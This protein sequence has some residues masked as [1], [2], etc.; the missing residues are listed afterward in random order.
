MWH[1]Q[2]IDTFDDHFR[3]SSHFFD[4]QKDDWTTSITL[5]YWGCKKMSEKS[6]GLFH[7]GRDK[8]PFPP[9][10]VMLQKKN[11]VHIWRRS[12]R[13]SPEKLANNE[14]EEGSSSL[15][16]SGDIAG[17]W[18][19]CSVVSTIL[20]ETAMSALI[21]PTILTLNQFVHQPASGR[22]LIFLSFLG[23]LCESISAE[24]EGILS[25]LTDAIKL[26][27]CFCTSS[28]ILC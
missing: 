13:E 27:V 19:T 7:E 11:K 8:A 22:C 9:K 24:Y 26:G 16:I 3:D 4:N 12:Q 1:T 15:V 20:S 14:I 10:K 25:E 21:E 28:L 18:W 23:A 6:F 2:A 5:S 17:N